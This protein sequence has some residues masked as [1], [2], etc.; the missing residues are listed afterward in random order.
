[1]E[2]IIAP[3]ILSA[4]F[5]QL[6]SEIEMINKSNAQWIH[7]DVM[8]G[9]FVPNITFGPWIVRTIRKLTDK[10]LDVHLMIEKPEKYFEDFK[11]AG[12]D[13]ITIHYEAS[14]HLHRSIQKIKSMGIKAGV[15][16][17]PHTNVIL[18]EDIV[19]YADLILLMSVNPGFGGQKFIPNTYKKIKDLQKIMDNQNVRSL[20]EVDG[21][22]SID[23]AQELINHGVNALVAGNAIFKSDNPLDYIKR[24]S[25]ITN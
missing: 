12:A 10:V 1:M 15:S 16:I 14:T 18:L 5:S 19:E 8:D 21:G 7:I 22:V 20:I 4:D 23:N 6:G 13:I 11:N 25:E 9:A 17:N 24:L 2:T 3:S